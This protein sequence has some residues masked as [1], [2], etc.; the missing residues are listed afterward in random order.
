MLDW[1]LSV[2]LS[3]L[4]DRRAVDPA[5]GALH[6]LSNLVIIVSGW[7]VVVTPRP[8]DWQMVN[9]VQQCR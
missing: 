1:E 7:A 4:Q 8:A 5:A 6:L 3:G 9:K 2:E